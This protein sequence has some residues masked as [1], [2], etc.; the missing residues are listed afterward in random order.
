MFSLLA[1]WPWSPVSAAVKTVLRSASPLTTSFA[2]FLQEYDLLALG[3]YLDVHHPSKGKKPRSESDNMKLA[4]K[5]GLELELVDG[6]PHVTQNEVLKVK[7]GVKTSVTSG[8][9]FS[10]EKDD[11]QEVKVA[12]PK[13]AAL[14]PPLPKNAVGSSSASSS[15]A[16]PVGAL[17]AV[18][19][20]A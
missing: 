5:L 14:A 13:V 12:H 17:S 1:R 18:F 9:K 20:T 16:N 8:K 11:L 3:K 7:K 4:K 19:L 2:L 6:V 15:G 10:G